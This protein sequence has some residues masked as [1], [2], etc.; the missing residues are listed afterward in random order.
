MVW[1]SYLITHCKERSQSNPANFRN[2][3]SCN[4][5]CLFAEIYIY[6]YMYILRN[7]NHVWHQTLFPSI[8]KRIF[9][10]TVFED[11]KIIRAL[12]RLTWLCYF[13]NVLCW[14]KSV[15]A[16]WKM[17]VS[18]IYFFPQTQEW[19]Q[20]NKA[21]EFLNLNSSLSGPIHFW[22]WLFKNAFWL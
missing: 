10:S 6:K 11:C 12:Q 22:K 2:I 9:S 21:L 1:I 15:E 13:M 5:N 19:C 8:K 17:C 16:F 7:R 4:V 20:V 18:Y 3:H 14:C